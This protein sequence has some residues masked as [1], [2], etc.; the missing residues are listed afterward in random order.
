MAI[1]ARI[2]HIYR[3][4]KD[5]DG[6]LF[7]AS[8]GFN[9]GKPFTKISVKIE[10]AEYVDTYINGF[11]SYITDKWNVGDEI[12]I[13]ITKKPYNGKDYFNFRTIRPVDPQVEARFVK[14]EKRLTDLESENK[15]PSN[16]SDVAPEDLPF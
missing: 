4:D 7:I 13:D 6:K 11:G 3:N 8:S 1:T 14:I 9:A 12:T 15:S 10:H 16:P 5:K 2:T